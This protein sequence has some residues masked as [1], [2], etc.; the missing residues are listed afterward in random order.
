MR[1]RGCSRPPASRRTGKSLCGGFTLLEV[2][3]AFSLLAG[4]LGL[5]VAIQ[6]GGLRQVRQGAD[7]SE[8]TLH[9]QSLLDGL[10][11]LEPIV[12]GV[13][14]GEF[15]QGRYHWRLAIEP[16][17]DPARTVTTPDSRTEQAPVESAETAPVVYRVALDVRWN[18]ARGEPAN[19]G[20]ALHFVTLRTRQPVNTVQP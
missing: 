20:S 8:A 4:G 5:L 3:L 6:S 14:E 11:V 17:D 9:A 18:L 13:R 7:V 10:G 12:P 15:A 19:A 1:V 16:I 2:L